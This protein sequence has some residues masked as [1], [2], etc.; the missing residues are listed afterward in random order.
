MKGL[1]DKFK[2]FADVKNCKMEQSWCSRQNIYRGKKSLLYINGKEAFSVNNL[3]E[4]VEI[5]GKLK[6]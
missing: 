1:P 4:L 6:L 2:V 3:H 5:V